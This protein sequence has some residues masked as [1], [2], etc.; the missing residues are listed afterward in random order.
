MDK[1]PEPIAICG[2]AL[3]LPGA[4]KTPAQF[5][6]F[7]TQKKDARA[8]IP[9]ERFDAEAFYSVSGKSGHIHSQY[10]YFLDKSAEVGAVDNSLFRMSQQEVQRMDPQ[11]KLLL[12]LARECFESAGEINWHGNNFGTYIG[13]FGDDWAAMAMKD[14][15]TKSP[16]KVTGYGDFMLANRISYEY[17][18]KGPSMT[19]RTGCSASLIGLHEACVAVRNGDCS[20]ALVGGC[21]LL[22]SPDMISD[23][24]EQGV[25][26]PN[27]SCRTFDAAADG[28]A[29][30]EAVN[31]I[32]IKPLSAAIRDGNPIRAIIRGS[33]TNAD[34]KTPGLSLPSA[35]SQEQM[36]RK[37]YQA[38]GIPESDVTQTAFVE[39]HGT[40]TPTGDPIEAEAVGNVFGNSGVY[41]G[42]VKPNVGHSEGA[43]GITS[44]IKAVLALENRIIPPN[45]KF[46]TP[47]PKIPFSGKDLRVP[48][49]CVVWPENKFER[50]SVNSFGIGGANAHVVLES[51]ARY[52]SSQG[53]SCIRTTR[54]DAYS[55]AIGIS[56]SSETA[57]MERADSPLGSDSKECSEPGNLILMTAN[58][59][60]SLQTQIRNIHIYGLTNGASIGDISY[61][62]A[63]R[64]QHLAHR[65]FAVVQGMSVD[66]HPGISFTGAS[67]SRLV[68]IFTGQG[69]QWPRMGIEILQNN[70]AFA[71]SIRAMDRELGNLP[72][73]P[74]WSIQE[75]L[76]KDAQCSKVNESAISQPLCTAIQIALVDALADLAIKPHSVLGHS[77][78][79]IA[80]AYAAGRISR[81]AAIIIAYYRGIASQAVLQSGA[82]AAIGLSWDK[83]ATYLPHGVVL[84]C[85]NSP[86]NVTISGDREAVQEAIESI[87]THN[88]GAFVRRLKVNTAYHSYHMLN[89]GGEYEA[90]MASV[91]EDETPKSETPF[92]SDFY[93]SV[94]GEFLPTSESV[95]AQYF[96][97]NLESPVLFLQAV[98]SLLAQSKDTSSRNSCL[99]EVG[100]HSA[101]SGPL[102]QILT[103]NSFNWPY[104]SCLHRGKDS[105]KTFLTALG[106]LWQ[107]GVEFDLYRL[108]NP[109]NTAKVLTNMPLYPWHHDGI[110]LF[111]N[112]IAH[113]WRYPR[114]SH[115]ELL[116][117]MILENAEDQ[118]SFRN[119]LQLEHVPW[120][121]DH[122]IHGDVVLPCAAYVTMAGEAC[123]R[124]HPSDKGNEF[125]GFCVKNMTI[126]TAMILEEN[127]PVEIITSL[128]RWRVTDNLE[129]NGW[130][131]KIL[132]YSG[133]EWTKHCS[134]SIESIT[135]SPPPILVTENVL[136]RKADSA[137]WYQAMWHV[138]ARYGP[139]FQGLKEIECTPNEQ[140]AKAIARDNTP[141]DCE[142]HYLIHPTTIDIFFQATA[143]AACNGKGH[144]M[145]RMNVPTFI[146]QMEIYNC[147]GDIEAHTSANFLAHGKIHARGYAIGTDG[148]LAMK[149]DK[150]KLTPLDATIE[151]DPHAGA[152]TTW[153]LEPSFITMS[154]LVEHDTEAAKNGSILQE[155]TF[156]HIK[157]ALNQVQDIEPASDT[158]RKFVSWMK[159]QSIP[160]T[161]RSL[162]TVTS[163]VKVGL[164]SSIAHAIEKITANIGKLVTDEISALE[165]LMADDSL[166]K[167]Y[168]DAKSTN[169]APYI[170]LLGHQKPN[171]RI[172]EIGAG[173]GG[174]T[175]EFLAALVNTSD[176]GKMWSSYTY[177]DISAGFFGT[178]KEKFKDFPLLEFKVLDITKDPLTQG[179]QRHSYDLIIATNVM[180]AVP[181]LQQALHNV[182]T[183]LQNDGTFYLEELCTDVKGINLTMGV[184]PGW[185]L[186]EDD[187]R[188]DEPYVQPERWDREL[189]DSGFAGVVDHMLDAPRP[190]QTHAYM[191]S[192]PAA[193][194]VLPKPITLIFD[195][196]TKQ[197][198]RILEIELS[199]SEVFEPTLQHWNTI[200]KLP[201]QDIICLLD[202]SKPFFMGIEASDFDKLRRVLAQVSESRDG[203][204]WL[205][206]SSQLSCEHPRWGQTPGA[207]RTIRK[208]MEVDIAVCEIDW[209]NTSS[210]KAVTKIAHAFSRRHLATQ[211][212]ELEYSIAGGRV[213]VPRIYPLN[214]NSELCK[215]SLCTSTAENAELDLTIG[216]AGRL[217]TLQWAARP[218]QE[219][220]DSQVVVEIMATGL[221]FRVRP[222]YFSFYNVSRIQ[223]KLIVLGCANRHGPHRT[224]K[225]RNWIGSCRG[226]SSCRISSSRSEY[227]R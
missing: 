101:L 94:T 63:C 191:I 96:R 168:Q 181:N 195:E 210:W 144:A 205:T 221:N 102:R 130:D 58:T 165:L 26:S 169:R 178:A 219:P 36:I 98:N 14:P 126:G 19:V 156:L 111:H 116:G 83:V 138:G 155:F 139:F 59:S 145:K 173:T 174:T 125:L 49:D 66:S 184:L 114:F 69:A 193:Q 54:K 50:I 4:L 72:T 175:R 123:R 183:L 157:R 7:L 48:V 190:Y 136:P 67:P 209:L 13:S 78:G 87:Q 42:S 44:I 122:N 202:V 20:A 216:M 137:K 8:R 197:A 203:I 81:R 127:K 29:R 118:P 95:D 18:L 187:G 68:M 214:I 97:R 37:A 217:D 56:R 180:H 76:R 108:T 53:D 225:P 162:E 89:I 1:L 147:P 93:S 31:M 163:E 17:D 70:A 77:S 194:E 15:L 55:D 110:H 43:S 107:Y 160:D 132:S 121:R 142:S 166:A 119:L 177:T 6:T 35:T 27:S 153:N 30:G 88:P 90:M 135:S 106:T 172:L 188:A 164:S 196:D 99:L 109:T 171:M 2:M 25:L 3:R 226:N 52:V 34:G 227:W 159:R 152:L 65:A 167:I 10:G 149:L 207:M 186:G 176:G 113:A 224:T 57:N 204:L 223:Q 146:K 182:H 71:S 28:Y 16:Y 151:T 161:L 201:K 5:W 199:Q 91:L 80:A 47:N 222:K 41:I 64:R 73:P 208:D 38:A 189:R 32:F 220:A 51:A 218:S 40:S 75:E 129:S 46:E 120:L 112:R 211:N 84:A 179:F 128:R 103:Q 158:M 140:I 212:L 45:I 185:W 24:A 141:T 86:S 131:F 9:F 154:A 82:M 198:A 148:S 23:M 104:A 79:E 133:I 206:R 150:I 33:A 61:T 115:H 85:N 117:S 124:L 143:L 134:G 21:N 74:S 11:Q 213:Y 62:L 60:E 170:K 192:Y 22:W 100:P 39:C 12:E 200:T 105:D 92:K 215:Q